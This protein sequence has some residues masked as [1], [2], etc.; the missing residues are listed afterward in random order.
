MCVCVCVCVC[1]HSTHRSRERP[2]SRAL[3]SSLDRRPAGGIDLVLPASYPPPPFP[4][5]RSVTHSDPSY[6]FTGGSCYIIPPLQ[7]GIRIPDDATSSK[8]VFAVKQTATLIF[9][10]RFLFSSLPS[11]G[12]LV[13]QSERREERGESVLERRE[14]K[15]GSRHMG[16]RK[17]EEEEGECAQMRKREREKKMVAAVVVSRTHRKKARREEREEGDRKR[18]G[19]GW[20]ILF[21][22]S[23]HSTSLLFPRDIQAARK[24]A[25]LTQTSRPSVRPEEIWTE[26]EA[27]RC[28]GERGR[29]GKRRKLINQS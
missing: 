24:Q 8:S 13:S 28:L 21:G 7:R 10:S 6:S 16:W 15:E 2:S 3:P 23:L 22:A 11:H 1:T 9:S 5:P 18:D 29:R 25:H 27:G 14:E 17:E 20:G 26:K 12:N 4:P 19:G